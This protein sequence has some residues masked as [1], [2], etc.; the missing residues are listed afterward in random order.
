MEQPEVITVKVPKKLKAQMKKIDINWS[1]YLRQ[2]VQKR[3]DE[4]KM[5]AAFQK[6]DEIKKTT[7]PTATEEI[8]KWIREDRER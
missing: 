2:C 1:E 5:R 4:E 3:L 8:V 6:L 7:K